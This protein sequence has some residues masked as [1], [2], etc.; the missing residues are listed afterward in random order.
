MIVERHYD[1]E[2]LISFLES[3]DVYAARDPHLATC[4][5]CSDTLDAFRLMTGVLHDPVVWQTN[6]LSEEPNLRTI[7]TLRAFADEMSREDAE[8][9]PIIVALLAS[10]RATWTAQLAEHPEWRTAG[11]VRGLVGAADQVIASL[12]VDG[13]ELTTLLTHLVAQL[14]AARYS[15][16]TI[17]KLRGAAWRQHAF[18]L[19]YVGRFP[20]AADALEIADAAYATVTIA[21]YDRARL[22]VVRT[23]VER[24]L[25]RDEAAAAAAQASA[26]VF[27]EAGDLDRL[28]SA[29]MV[30][31]HMLIKAQDYRAALR[32]L[33][34]AELECSAAMQVANR[35]RLLGNIAICHGYLKHVERA[36]HYYQLSTDIFDE[37][38]HATES[39][40]N[41]MN[42]AAML[43]DAGRVEDAAARLCEVM[44]DFKEL[45]MAP[46]AAYSGLELSELLLLKGQYAEV[47]AICQAAIDYF[48]EAGVPHGW[49][50]MTA[51]AY[52]REAAM[53]KRATPALARQACHYIR[54]LPAEP[55]LLFLPAP[56]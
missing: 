24:A 3:P 55:A 56:D 40:R 15:G 37:L 43:R 9:A 39:V 34:A 22:D 25:D 14:S 30:E 2:T 47:E 41:R 7:A 4:T 45:G 8:A 54:R 17:A 50:A 49:K 53:Q 35:A 32:L 13:L 52:M 21:D 26:R 27:R 5:S 10:P 31:A 11:V 44:R 16:E 23:L 48:R 19:F 12:P 18:A 20:E 1:E 51:L 36:L 42:I 46:E 33:Q 29:Y 28:A 6:E 38:G